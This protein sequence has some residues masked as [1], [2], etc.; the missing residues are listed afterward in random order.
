MKTPYHQKPNFINSLDT[1]ENLCKTK[2]NKTK[3]N[4][5]PKQTNTWLLWLGKGTRSK[6]LTARLE[7]NFH[8]SRETPVKWEKT[9]DS[10]QALVIQHQSLK[11]LFIS[12]HMARNPFLKVLHGEF[13][14][15]QRG[16]HWSGAWLGQ[17][18]APLRTRFLMM[19]EQKASWGQSTSWHLHDP[20]PPQSGMCV[21]FPRHSWLP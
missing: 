3:Q 14:G 18:T 6:I 17:V 7:D 21:T 10:N 5:Q 12:S 19:R 4:T 9:G 15:G 13:G 1:P 11:T 8:G 16:S 2:Q 20:G